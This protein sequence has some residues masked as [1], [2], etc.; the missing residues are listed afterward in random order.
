[1]ATLQTTG[2]A[3]A[4]AQVPA[5]TTPQI[6]VDYWLPEGTDIARTRDGMVS[7]EARVAGR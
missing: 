2:A 5:T 1:M 3:E 6:V 7:L 4:V